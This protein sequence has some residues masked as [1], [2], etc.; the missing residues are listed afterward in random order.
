MVDHVVIEYLLYSLPAA[1]AFTLLVVVLT[2]LATRRP[3]TAEQNR[4]TNRVR[5]LEADHAADMAQISGLREE[6]FYLV[7]LIS[8]MADL[9][10]Q[11][12]LIL[13]DDVSAYLSRRHARSP[14]VAD[15]EMVVM[16]QHALTGFFDSGELHQLAFE[17]G[18]DFEN[19]PG[20][21]KED[22]AR[23]MVLFVDRRGQLEMLVRHI[24]SMRPNLSIP[25][26]G[27]GRGPP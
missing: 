13:P 25:G 1:L 19:L 8:M 21:R 6:V 7:R 18:I 10:E 20:N 26:I 27:G 17:L 2:I 22:K 5:L 4:L 15:P 3:D 12:G 24:Q 16:V 11:S 23:E 14:I 9:V